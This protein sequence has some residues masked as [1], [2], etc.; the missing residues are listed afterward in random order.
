MSYLKEATAPVPQSEALPGQ[1][2]NSAGGYSYALDDFGRLERF[3]ILGTEGGSYYAGQ[4]QLTIENVDVIRRCLVADGTRTIATIVDVSKAGRAPKNDPAIL[5]L[6]VAAAEGDADARARALAAIPAVCRT[7]THLFMFVS[8]VEDLRGWGRGLRR[9]VAAWYDRD[10]LDYQLVKYRQRD[11]WTHRDVLRLAHPKAKTPEQQAA[12]A[13]AVGKPTGTLPGKSIE[14]FERAQAAETPKQTRDLILEYGS[15]L[16][17]EALKTDHLN[18]PE[19][20]EALLSVGMPITALIR[21]L[22]TMTKIGLIAPQSHATGLVLEALSNPD[23]LRK[24]RVHP[25]QVLS[26]LLTYGRGQG[27]RGSATW[28]PV[29]SVID[30]LDKAFYLTFGNVEPTGKNTMLALDVSGSMGSGEIAG[31]PGLSPRIGSAA[32]AL[33]TAAVEKD[34]YIVGF[35]SDSGYWSHDAKLT[36]LNI[37]ARQRLDDAVKAVSRLPFGGTDCA[38]PMLH[39]TEKDLAIETFV[40]YTDSETWA[41]SIHPTVALQQYRR[42]TGIPAKLVVVGMVSN[43]FTIADPNDA[44]MLDVVGF[45]TA[46]PNLISEF[47]R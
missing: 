35:T 5:A 20:W 22:A 45:D 2:A 14:A 15:A 44:G 4:R 19:V 43:G 29:T 18:K 17:R 1:V 46:T 42:K 3:L 32:M 30:A 13:F 8:F 11:G 24:G 9:G 34:P 27:V 10:D 31:V 47:A 25:I 36:P 39:A 40:V 23:R 41:G 28:Q 12:F 33:I 6:A 7:G 21:N 37:S 26:A 16:P 38:L